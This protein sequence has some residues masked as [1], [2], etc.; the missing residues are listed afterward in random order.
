MKK[1]VT[2]ILILVGCIL[3]VR[4]E[5]LLTLT[6]CTYELQADRPFYA[7]KEQSASDRSGKMV[8]SPDGT[9]GWVYSDLNGNTIPQTSADS[10]SVEIDVAQDGPYQI[11]AKKDGA[12]VSS[13]VFTVFHVYVPPFTVSL[14]N[15][16]D[17]VEIKIKVDNFVP[18]IYDGYPGGA[19]PEYY[20]G[21]N[22]SY[23]QTPITM[24]DYP[25]GSWEGIPE[26][27]NL[28]DDRDQPAT[29]TV[30]VRDR[31]GFEW[32]SEPVHY[33]SFLP[34]SKMELTFDNKVKVDGFSGEDLGQAPLEVAFRNES[35]NVGQGGRYQ[36]LLYKDTADYREQTVTLED[37]LIDNRFRTET[38][39]NYVYQ[40]PGRYKVRLIAING[41]HNHCSD[42]T[43]AQFIN[44]VLSLVNVPNVFTPNGDGINDV[45]YVQTLSVESFKAVII[46]RWGNKLYEWTNP[47]EGWDGRVNGRYASPGTYYYIVTARGREKNSPPQ[48]VKKGPLLLVR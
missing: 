44:V 46:N 3:D 42:T 7:V 29:Y 33:T 17:C 21:R 4:A 39:F 47:E 9:N 22:G 43:A 8:F 36:W 16:Y 32:T 27:V 24:P 12:A 10:S 18:A 38:D 6:D 31:F 34:I 40:N 1:I 23:R 30:K 5:G 37:S 35:R 48:Y 20:L 15:E 41:E 11:V 25:D 14:A 13:V 28:R 45:F 26:V 2:F 19:R